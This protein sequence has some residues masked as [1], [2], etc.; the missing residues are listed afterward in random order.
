MN[1]EE[2][3]DIY[4]ENEKKTGRTLIRHKE[5]LKPG[6]YLVAVQAVILNSKNEILISLRSPL[7]I[8]Y[9]LKWECNGGALLS[10]E[11]VKEAIVREI[12]E[13]LGIRL[14]KEDAIHLKTV[15]DSYRFKEV[16]LF[17]KDVDIKDIRF[18]DEE[19]IE[20]K[21][22]TIDEFMDMFEKGDIVDN[23]DFDREDYK[24]C[25]ELLQR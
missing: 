20:A 24:K 6:E 14:N 17:Q 15:K 11:D 21:W 18:T 2:V 3:I 8:K 1:N 12:S 16:F 9:P 5:F 10:G 13:E 7:K 19:S 22:V 25:L 4:D 23:V